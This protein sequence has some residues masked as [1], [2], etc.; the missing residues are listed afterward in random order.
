MLFMEVGVFII[1]GGYFGLFL[2]IFV[3][4][5]IWDS[6]LDEFW[7]FVLDFLIEG[8][9]ILYFLLIVFVL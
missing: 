1:G 8:L 2:K 4:E 5:F 9:V 3:V 7:R 6:F